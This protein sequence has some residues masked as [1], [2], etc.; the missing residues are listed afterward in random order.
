MDKEW[1]DIPF[2]VR[3]GA[4]RDSINA[5]AS[6]DA[7]MDAKAV[8]AG[9]DHAQGGGT[10]SS[11]ARKTPPSH[12]NSASGSSTRQPP[13]FA[14]LFGGAA[15]RSTMHSRRPLPAEFATDMR[16]LHDK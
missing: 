7:L 16:L 3:D 13:W 4:L 12:S 11:G 14:A 15:D 9:K 1:K 10:S 8:A 6:T 2:E 5:V